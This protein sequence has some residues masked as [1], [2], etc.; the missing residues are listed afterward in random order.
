MVSLGALWLPILLGGVLVFIGS[1]IVWMVLPH[2]RS[3]YAGLPNEDAV[4]E[5]LGSPE[6]GQYHVPHSGSREDHG[7]EEVQRKF[8]EGPVAMINVF[9]DGQPA[10]GK[11]F[12]QWFVYCLAVSA[13]AAY[14]AA[15]TLAPGTEYLKVFQVTGTVSWA[16]YGVAYLGDAIWFGRPWGFTVKMVLDALFYGLL[17]AGV[18]GWLW[19]A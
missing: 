7:S 19:P 1:S 15:E 18:F 11:R 9:P 13:L 4:R 14:V 3:D 16:A 5:A 12:A 10:M 8:D 6:P 17:T 2:H